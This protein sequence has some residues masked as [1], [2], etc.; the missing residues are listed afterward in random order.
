MRAAV[1]A[2]CAS[3]EKLKFI[4]YVTLVS[5]LCLL[6]WK[7]NYS[8]AAVIVAEDQSDVNK[9]VF[10]C[11]NVIFLISTVLRVRT[12]VKRCDNEDNQ[13]S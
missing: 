5:R 9:H 8:H 10:K 11:I 1:E 13:K 6:K 12:A 7:V 3:T 2:L 4:P